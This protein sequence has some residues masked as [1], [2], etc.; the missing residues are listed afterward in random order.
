MGSCSYDRDVY[1]ASSYSGWGT[2]SYSSTVFKNTSLSEDLDPKNKK[3]VSKSKNPIIIVLDVTG[4]NID[5]ARL[6][7][8]KLPMFYG[9]IESKKYLED[10]DICICAV[11]DAK[12]DKYPIQIGTPAKGIEIDNWLEKIV[13][14]GCGGGNRVESYELMAYYL[15][16]N[17]EFEKDSNPIVF[18]IADEGTEKI[19]DESEVQKI[20]G[21]NC[22]AGINAWELLNERFNNNVFCMLNKYCGTHFVDNMTDS[23]K[24]VL[25]LQHTIR[26]PE[27]KA[28]IDLI[29][30]I[31]AIQKQELTTYAIDMKNRGQTEKRIEGVTESL[32][33]LSDSLALSTNIETDLPVEMKLR[34]SGN[35]GRRL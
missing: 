27:E 2:S 13:L 8:D 5:F 12:Y 16:N 10:F 14:E 25:P 20:L 33:E 4:S 19:V 7:Y 9:E 17:C 24:E 22:Q 26:I 35:K 18:F 21:S 23:W 34:K 29:L 11:G 6:V 15:A 28:I 31:I 30:G 32:K 3:I 1:S